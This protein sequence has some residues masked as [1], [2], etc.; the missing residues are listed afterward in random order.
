VNTYS[1]FI[2]EKLKAEQKI[3]WHP[4]Q[5]LEKHLEHSQEKYDLVFIHTENQFERSKKHFEQI[6]L[7][8]HNDSLVIFDNLYLSTEMQELWSFV[9]NHPKVKVTIDGFYFGFVFFREEQAKEN[10]KIRLH[11]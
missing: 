2:K 4:I 1:E 10:F 8:L 6:L 9:K 7:H 5:T 3:E 11:L